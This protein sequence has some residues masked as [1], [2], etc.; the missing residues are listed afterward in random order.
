MSDRMR[1]RRCRP[2]LSDGTV[3]RGKCLLDLYNLF[4]GNRFRSFRQAGSYHR[5]RAAGMSAATKST[6]AFR[7]AS[8]L[9]VV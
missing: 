4:L 7:R 2:L 3:H 8:S 9:V 1:W 5:G 6:P